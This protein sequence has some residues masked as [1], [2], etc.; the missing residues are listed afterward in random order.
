MKRIITISLLLVFLIS[1]GGP[2]ESSVVWRASTKP[3]AML[4]PQAKHKIFI[5]PAG[6]V[7]YL[8]DGSKCSVV[9]PTVCMPSRTFGAFVANIQEEAEKKGR[10]QVVDYWLQR[11]IISN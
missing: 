5:L 2:K 4:Q 3:E 7:F 11:S 6:T 10:D 1:C 8:P 9:E